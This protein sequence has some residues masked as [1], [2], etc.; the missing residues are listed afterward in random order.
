[1]NLEGT[2]D[3][4]NQDIAKWVSKLSDMNTDIYKV[5]KAV[6]ESVM[7]LMSYCY[8]K[9]CYYHGFAR[10]FCMHI[11][12]NIKSDSKVKEG[13]VTFTSKWLLH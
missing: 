4:L 7:L 2:D 6:L 1:M 5:T 9:Q 12:V 8:V 3:M 13:E 10:C 11:T